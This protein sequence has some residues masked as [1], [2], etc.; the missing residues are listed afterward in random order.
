MKKAKFLIIALV[1]TLL[2]ITQFAMVSAAPSLDKAAFVAGIVSKVTLTTD[3]AT[4]FTSVQITLTDDK[5]KTHTLVVD[6]QTADGLGL[7]WYD[8]DGNPQLVET[9]PASLEVP[10]DSILTDEI[11]HPVANAL[12][13]YFWEIPGVEYDLIVSAHDSGYGFGVIAQALWLT[14]KMGGDADT[15]TAILEAKKTGNYSAF[16]QED[17]TVFTDWGQFKK[18]ILEKDKKN[19]LGVVVSGKTADNSGNHGNGG[20]PASDNGNNKDKDKTNNGNN[21]NAG[22][23]DNNGNNGNNGNKD[24]NGKN[25]P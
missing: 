17:G 6:E 12:A 25:K 13:T 4:G 10:V 21:G 11:H 2:V 22:N 5:G 15:L 23:P 20:N 14:Q 16:A 8:E 3:L 7:L 9:L 18:A 1:V 24:N 19:N